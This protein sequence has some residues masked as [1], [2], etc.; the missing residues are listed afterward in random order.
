LKRKKQESDMKLY[1]FKPSGNCWKI[2]M[3]LNMIGQNAERHELDLR[4]SEHKQAAFLAINPAGQVPTFV[5]GDVTI[6]DSATI[7]IYLAVKYAGPEWFPTDPVEIGEVY[8]W[9]TAVGDGVDQGTF[10]ARMVKLFDAPYDYE[11]SVARGEALLQKLDN[12]LADNDWLVGQQVS[13]ADIH[14]Y[15]YIR[16]SEEGGIALDKYTHLNAWFKRI[17]ALPGYIPI[18][19]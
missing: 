9:F 1:N 10:A 13:V 4:Q 8:K 15:P 3:F 12:H 18:D 19:G 5:D 2:R 17:E 14:M 11:A 16:L 6:S 7:L